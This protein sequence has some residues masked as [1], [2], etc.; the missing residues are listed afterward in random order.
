MTSFST[1]IEQ[2]NQVCL[3]SIKQYLKGDI[4]SV[5]KVKEHSAL[6]PLVSLN[7]YGCLVVHM[8]Y[9]VWKSFYIEVIGCVFSVSLF[10]EINVLKV[11]NTCL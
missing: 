1:Q 11:N 10:I 3:L 9:R 8:F 6:I 5:P 4:D 2:A 7:W